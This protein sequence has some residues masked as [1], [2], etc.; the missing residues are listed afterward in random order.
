MPCRRSFFEIFLNAGKPEEK[1]TTIF[2]EMDFGN[3]KKK[4]FRDLTF[5]PSAYYVVAITN[6]LVFFFLLIHRHLKFSNFYK[7]FVILVDTILFPNMK[8]WNL[9]RRSYL[10]IIYRGFRKNFTR[11]SVFL[12]LNLKFW[13]Y[14]AKTWTIVN[15][16][17]V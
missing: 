1:G 10:I 12:F 6:I 15:Y 2:G 14:F 16:F 8:T 5:S 4:H 17:I 9:L 3:S 7:L 11:L 13:R